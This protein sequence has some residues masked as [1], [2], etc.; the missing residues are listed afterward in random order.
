MVAR[1]VGEDGGVEVE[2][3]DAAQRQGVGG[4]LHGDVRAA[5]A[6]QL[7][8]QTQKIERLRSGIG[9]FQDAAGQVVLDG[10][11][12]GGGF[13]GGAKYGI[14]QVCRPLLE[15]NNDSALQE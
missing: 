4:D 9:G 3:V 10:A 2:T 13:A 7:A 15:I 8:E 11:D 1:Q 6:F 12:H 5:G 14:D